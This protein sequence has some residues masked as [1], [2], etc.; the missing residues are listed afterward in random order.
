M[1]IDFQDYNNHSLQLTLTFT[2]QFK[3]IPEFNWSNIPRTLL[4]PSKSSLLVL[5]V[6]VTLLDVQSPSSLDTLRDCLCKSG[7]VDFAWDTNFA[8]FLCV[9]RHS[10]TYTKITIR[11][12]G[13]LYFSQFY[14]N[15]IPLERRLVVTL[16]RA[17]YKKLRSSAKNKYHSHV[18]Q[19]YLIYRG[20]VREHHVSVKQTGRLEWHLI[21]SLK[22]HTR[23][24]I[25]FKVNFW[26]SEAFLT[27]PTNI[28]RK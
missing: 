2:L 24:P 5:V 14:G 16:W 10:C 11:L 28:A 1:F 18:Y 17:I 4:S 6:S 9:I 25:K 8:H 12:I 13:S 20:D 23:K 21:C 15:E 3:N 22:S 19:P 26:K 7:S 27:D